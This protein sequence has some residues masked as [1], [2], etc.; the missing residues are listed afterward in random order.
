MAS[1]FV[2]D[3]SHLEITVDQEFDFPIVDHIHGVSEPLL[4][5]GPYGMIFCDLISSIRAPR[6]RS[7]HVCFIM[8]STHTIDAVKAEIARVW[9]VEPRM[10]QLKF[11]ICGPQKRSQKRVVEF[12]E[13]MH[14]MEH[15]IQAQFVGPHAPVIGNGWRVDCTV[16]D[17]RR[18]RI[19][20]KRPASDEAGS[21]DNKGGKAKRPKRA[22][23]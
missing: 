22:A 16:R 23:W 1:D 13:N 14:T 10:Q 11:F 9:D 12:H 4:P 3:S 21:K 17:L 5:A 6:G 15:V 20:Q 2:D 7:H 18:F 19:T 8:S